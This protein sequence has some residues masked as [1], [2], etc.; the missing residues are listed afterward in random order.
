V[1]LA[2]FIHAFDDRDWDDAT[3]FYPREMPRP[4]TAEG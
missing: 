2:G 3:V 1:A 4:A